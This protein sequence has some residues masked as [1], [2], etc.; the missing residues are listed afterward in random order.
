MRGNFRAAKTKYHHGELKTAL[1]EA[2]GGLV[3]IRGLEA[4]SLREVARRAGVSEAA[5]YRHFENVA[6]LLA[7]VA[8]EGFRMLQ[9]DLDVVRDPGNLAA[10][11]L[12]FAR[13]YPGRYKLMF[14]VPG[15]T[16]AARIAAA[17]KLVVTLGGVE[18]LAQLHG[19]AMLEVE[20][21]VSAA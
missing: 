5:P 19:R 12:A 1:I 14:T 16:Q 7:A 3:D 17:K 18:A 2:A 11:Y 9:A 10:T 15:M 21:L 6:A 8:E 13:D 4:V 20:G